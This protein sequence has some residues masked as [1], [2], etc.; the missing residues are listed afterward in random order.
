MKAPE[1]FTDDFPTEVLVRGRPVDPE[2]RPGEIPKRLTAWFNYEDAAAVR[3]VLDRLGTDN[4]GL[5]IRVDIQ[6]EAMGIDEIS[7]MEW[8]SLIISN[9]YYCEAVRKRLRRRSKSI[10]VEVMSADIIVGGNR[11]AP[12]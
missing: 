3:E 10:R 5:N 4:Y 9:C 11:D 6:V 7:G 2:Q 1:R 12:K 8:V